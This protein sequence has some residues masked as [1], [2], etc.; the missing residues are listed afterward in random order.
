M[1]NDKNIIVLANLENINIKG[2]N[3]ILVEYLGGNSASSFRY[4]STDNSNKNIFV[5]FL[6]SPRNDI[7]LYKFKMEYKL[8]ELLNNFNGIAKTT[9]KM[10]EYIEHN[11]LPI[12]YYISEWIEGETLKAKLDKLINPNLDEIIDVVHRCTSATAY[13]SSAIS[14]RDFHPG[15][16]FFLDDD[17][18]W[19]LNTKLNLQVDPKVIVTDFG[20]AVMPLAFSYEDEGLGNQDTYQHSNRRIEGSFRSLPPETFNDPI[21]AFMYSPGCGEAWAIGVLFYKLIAGEDI[22]NI[23]SISEYSKLIYSNELEERINEKILSVE[24]RLSDFILISIL[25]GL[26]KVNSSLRMS[27]G[28]AAGLFWDYRFGDLKSKS[29]EFQEKYIEH[30]RDYPPR[31][32]GDYDCY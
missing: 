16:I 31:E 10:Y 25:R 28:L 14:H 2:I 18:E 22:L 3:Y 19:G 13:I 32:P 6:I 29:K 12:I 17:R 27:T 23:N 5:K 4:T 1:R 9:P 26:L 11:T 21:N 30:K 24:I 7:E 15:N 8:T 20:N